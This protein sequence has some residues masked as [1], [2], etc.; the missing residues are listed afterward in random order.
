MFCFVEFQ[1]G[2]FEFIFQIEVFLN[3]MNVCMYN[4]VVYIWCEIDY[5]SSVQV[6]LVRGVGKGFFVGGNFDFVFSMMNNDDML[7]NVWKEG[8]DFVYNMINCFKLII[9]VI[10]GFVV[11][12]GLVVVLFVDIFIVVKNVKFI[13]SYIKLGV[14][15]GDFVVIF[16]LLLCG[17]VKV[18]YYLFIGK[19]IIGEEVECI[20][21]VFL[22]VEEVELYDIVL[23]IVQIIIVNS[24]FVVC[25]FKYLINGWLCMMGFNFDYFLVLEMF[26]FKLFDIQEGLVVMQEK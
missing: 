12:V 15:V 18:K 22:C 1:Q 9:L 26:G 2:I 16:W 21:M 5:D 25:W 8:K 14:V 4:E 3:I 6:V 23:D 11:G 7:L 20:G 17:M 19:S 13:D 24:F 10:Y